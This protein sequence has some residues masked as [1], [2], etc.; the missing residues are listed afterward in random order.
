L[1]VADGVGTS[2]AIVF[3]DGD[4]GVP[5]RVVTAPATRKEFLDGH[6]TNI[7]LN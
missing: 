5:L 3:G 6:D 4:P 2:I 7:L 1:L